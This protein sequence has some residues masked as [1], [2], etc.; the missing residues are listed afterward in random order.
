MG[1]LGCDGVCRCHNFK[2]LIMFRRSDY[3]P[4]H[5]NIGNAVF[6][7]QR[8][9]LKTLTSMTAVPALDFQMKGDQTAPASDFDLHWKNDQL[10]LL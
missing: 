10:K 9:G 8:K 3:T 6:F 1:A 7:L 4:V 2:R 5:G